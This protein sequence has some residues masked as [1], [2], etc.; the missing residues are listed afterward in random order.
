VDLYLEWNGDLVLTP[1]GSAQTAVNWD[2]ARERIIRS[3]LT[4]SAQQLP[5]GSY[6][7]ADYVFDIT[8]G[9]GAGALVDQ[10]PDQAYILGLTQRMRQ[11]VLSDASADPGQVPVI[12][13]TQPEPDT[14]QVFVSVPL[15]DGTQGSVSITLG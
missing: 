3:F 13:I 1:N 8:F 2:Q 15:I 11:A 9:E 5:D 4:N 12:V 7:P 6:T 14:Y 10:N